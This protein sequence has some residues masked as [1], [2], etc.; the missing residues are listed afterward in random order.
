MAV[1]EVAEG[2][3][4]GHRSLKE[5]EIE[6]CGI[7]VNNV[8]SLRVL[9]VSLQIFPDFTQIVCINICSTSHGMAV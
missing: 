1:E 9:L 3:V 6:A 5:L 8:G 4:E 7:N 2:E